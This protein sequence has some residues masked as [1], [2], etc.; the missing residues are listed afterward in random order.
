MGTDS[1]LSSHLKRDRNGKSFEGHAQAIV[2][3]F[4]VLVEKHWPRSQKKPNEHN[5]STEQS[6]QLQ[7]TFCIGARSSLGAVAEL[8]SLKSDQ[9]EESGRAFP[10]K[11]KGSPVQVNKCQFITWH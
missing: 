11:S 6:I 1:T 3:D 2:P 7:I 5:S 8:S 9:Q 10:S 4:S